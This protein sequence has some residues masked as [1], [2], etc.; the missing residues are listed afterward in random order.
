LEERK[1]REKWCNYI[2]NSEKENKYKDLRNLCIQ[3]R[4]RQEN[5]MS[6]DLRTQAGLRR[7]TQCQEEY[8]E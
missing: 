7:S 5:N 6:C 1:G 4:K 2:I 8:P 3:L